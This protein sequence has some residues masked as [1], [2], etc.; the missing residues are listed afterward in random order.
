[1]QTDATVGGLSLEK[2]KL[3]AGAVDKRRAR[4]TVIQTMGLGLVEGVGN[5]ASGG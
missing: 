3:V 4:A 1:M 2:I 5:R